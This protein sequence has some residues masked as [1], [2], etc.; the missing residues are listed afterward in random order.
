MSA[1]RFRKRPVEIEAV[2]FTG[3]N[4]DEVV[5]F[6]GGAALFGMTD[7][8]DRGDD[9]EVIAS[10]YDKLHSTWVGVKAGQWII[11]GVQGELYPCDPTVFEQTYEPVTGTSTTGGPVLS[12]VTTTPA[13]GTS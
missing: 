4:E 9:P 13:G 2:Q 11:R 10:V 1:S 8:E 12:N 6:A 5:A 3:S 7:P